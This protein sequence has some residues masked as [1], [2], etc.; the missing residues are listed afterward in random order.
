MPVVVDPKSNEFELTEIVGV[1][2]ALTVPVTA[3][4]FS[5]APVLVLVILPET[6]PTAAAAL[7]RALIVVVTRM[8]P[9]GDSVSDALYVVPS[10]DTSTPAGAAMA[11]AEVKL[12]P[13]TV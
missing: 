10:R 5:V 13:F 7:M 11:I 12:L 3:T 2:S 8:P 6:A 1:G 9:A 4:S